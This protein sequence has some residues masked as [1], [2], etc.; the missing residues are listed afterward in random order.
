MSDNAV[1]RS[2]LASNQSKIQSSLF[3][4]NPILKSYGTVRAPAQTVRMS[5]FT[6]I[7]TK[8]TDKKIL[9]KSLKELNVPISVANKGELLEVRG[10][11]GEKTQAEFMIKQEN[12]YDF[13]FVNNGQTYEL[14]ADIAFW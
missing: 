9:E 3:V 10:H 11:R 7:T 12:G 4:A 8:L 5:H 6:S 2:S 13:G 1:L 14:V